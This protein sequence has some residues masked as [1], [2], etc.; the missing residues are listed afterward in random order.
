MIYVILLIAMIVLP[1][2]LVCGA[3]EFQFSITM[4]QSIIL[5]VNSGYLFSSLIIT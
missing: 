3:V 2:F 5:P 1:E 4:A